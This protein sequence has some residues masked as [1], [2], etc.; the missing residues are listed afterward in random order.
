MKYR[1]PES[2]IHLIARG[3]LLRGENVILCRA[4]GADW[5]FLPG[6]HIEDGEPSKIALARELHEEISGGE[7][8]VS[9]FLGACEN[10]FLLEEGVLQHEMNIVFAVDVTGDVEPKAKEDHI[11]FVAIPKSTLKD[12]KILPTAIKAGII[13]WIG[14]GQLFFNEI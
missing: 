9:S 4:K 6:G 5:F 11:E 2:H 13:S 10:I 3:L 8:S 12:Q 1:G 14:N 7:Y